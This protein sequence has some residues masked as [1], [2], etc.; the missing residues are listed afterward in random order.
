MSLGSSGALKWPLL[1]RV[2]PGRYPLYGWFHLRKW[3]VDQLLDLTLN[4]VLPIHTSLYQVPWFRLLGARIGRRAELSTAAHVTPDLLEVGDASFVADSVSLGASRVEGGYLTVG[5]VKVGRET[6][7]F[8]FCWNLLKGSALETFTHTDEATGVKDQRIYSR[9][10]WIDPNIGKARDRVV[11]AYVPSPC[12]GEEGPQPAG[13]AS[14]AESGRQS[15]TVRESPTSLPSPEGQEPPAGKR[16]ARV[17]PSARVPFYNWSNL[18]VKD[19]LRRYRDGDKAP[20]FLCLPDEAPADDLWSYTAQMNSELRD[21]VYDDRGRK[22]SVWR[23]IPRRPNH[24]WDCEAMF[25]V[26]CAI[27]SIIGADGPS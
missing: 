1:G 10:D 9:R 15:G 23:P 5:P 19:I 27:V 2:Q 22:V 14:T 16:A 17:P 18:H 21:Q 4:V 20:K 7:R 25:I 11:L 26:F 12:P 3:F 8:W 24:W 6:K 13:A